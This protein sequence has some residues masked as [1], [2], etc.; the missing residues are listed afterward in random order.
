MRCRQSTVA[1]TTTTTIR[2]RTTLTS[3]RVVFVRTALPPLAG[4]APNIRCAQRPPRRCGDN[5][6]VPQP[7]ASALDDLRALILDPRRL[8]RAVAAGRRRSEHPTHRRVEL[9]WVDLRGDAHLQVVRY[10]ERQSFTE[11]VALAEAPVAVDGLLAEP[12]GNWHV[13][14][15][16]ETVQ[17]RVTK[18]G[19]AQ[20]HRS[21]GG[22]LAGGGRAG[23]GPAGGGPAGDSGA[24]GTA[25]DGVL[26]LASHDRRKPRMLEPGDAYLRA[27]GISDESSRIKPSRQAKYRQ[28]EEFLRALDP[29]LAPAVDAAGTDALRVA[30]LG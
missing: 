20:V 22:G 24:G 14:G 30:D 19:D 26:A 21:A 28:V 8:V 15:A 17:V 4:P 9:R 10:D 25:A 29:V 23:G 2:A 27:V 6:E 13:V 12:Y 18:K 11:N 5:G 7:L 1:T 3:W 16:A